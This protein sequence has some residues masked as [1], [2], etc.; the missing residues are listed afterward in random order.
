MLG[1]QLRNAIADR[2][3]VHGYDWRCGQTLLHARL[4]TLRAAPR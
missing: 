1:L 3:C 2:A 4:L